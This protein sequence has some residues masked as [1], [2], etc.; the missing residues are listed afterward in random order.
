MSFRMAISKHLED[1]YNQEIQDQKHLNK[2][3]IEAVEFKKR[4]TERLRSLK[5]L[6]H[7]VDMSEIWNCHY[8]AYLLHHSDNTEDYRLAH[9]YADQAVKMGSK[10]TRWLY[11]ATYDRWLISQG[12]KQ[13]FGT[14]FRK[15][16]TGWKRLP[17]EKH[18]SDAERLSYFVPPLKVARKKYIEKIT[19]PK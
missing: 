2:N 12:A 14:Q 11:A 7:M 8:A 4:Q 13:H 6:L 18:V 19:L 10:V 5:N 1:L 3:I 17:T 15:T 9:K 16:K